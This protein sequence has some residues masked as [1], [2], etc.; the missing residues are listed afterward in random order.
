MSVPNE[1]LRYFVDNFC[2]EFIL[3]Y[4]RISMYNAR[5]TSLIL[6]VI[7]ITLTKTNC[8][9]ISVHNGIAL[10]FA[11]ASIYAL[12]MQNHVHFRPVIIH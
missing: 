3:Q 8:N 5:I 11:I 4:C 9:H 1:C 6:A 7:E 2:V 12:A 10:S